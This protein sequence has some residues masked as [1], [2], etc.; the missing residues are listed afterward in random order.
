MR[1]GVV[2]MIVVMHGLLAVW[3]GTSQTDGA[4]SSAS[5]QFVPMSLGFAALD[6]VRAEEPALE[7]DLIDAHAARE[8]E[9]PQVTVSE[10]GQCVAAFI[11]ASDADVPRLRLGS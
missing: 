11:W 10:D 8:I 6:A 1:V 3:F 2:L 4:G 5:V 9:M 7:I